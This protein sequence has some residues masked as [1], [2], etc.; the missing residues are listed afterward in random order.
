MFTILAFSEATGSMVGL[1]NPFSKFR[2]FFLHFF[3]L[4]F[5]NLVQIQVQ[6]TLLLMKVVKSESSSVVFNSLL[7][8]WTIQSMEFSRPEYWSW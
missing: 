5:L 2:G 7:S 4:N 3:S 8:T 6:I 1:I